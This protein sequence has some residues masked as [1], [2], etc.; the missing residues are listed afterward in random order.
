M[1]GIIVA[2]ACFAALT[3]LS[4][5]LEEPPA[6]Q[7]PRAANAPSPSLDSVLNRMAGTPVMRYFEP[8]LEMREATDFLLTPAILVQEAISPDTILTYPPQ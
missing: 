6:Y 4:V 5:E 2:A 8:S 3:L 7:A 1:L